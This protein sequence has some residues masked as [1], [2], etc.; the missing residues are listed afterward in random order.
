MSLGASI[1]PDTVLTAADNGPRI[2]NTANNGDGCR[3]MITLGNKKFANK[4]EIS[5]LGCSDILIKLQ[6][7]RKSFFVPV[8]P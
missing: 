7:T 6:I 3:C 1:T 5:D 2:V 8:T 4:M